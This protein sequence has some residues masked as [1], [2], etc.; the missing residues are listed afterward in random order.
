MRTESSNFCCH[1]CQSCCTIVRFHVI[2]KKIMITTRPNISV[3]GQR[4]AQDRVHTIP[5]INYVSLKA[6]RV[7]VSEIVGSKCIWTLPREKQN[8]S[9]YFQWK[10]NKN[11]NLRS[12]WNIWTLQLLP[13]TSQKQNLAWRC[14]ISLS[15]VL[16]KLSLTPQDWSARLRILQAGEGE[17]GWSSLLT[18][19]RD[20][21]QF[22]TFC[23]N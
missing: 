21:R 8:G 1:P 2:F 19:P 9:K 16:I 18:E 15:F 23:S 22:A 5:N 13:Y 10:L 11:M 4:E 6:H 17:E 7:W 14:L 12:K 20:I 3:V